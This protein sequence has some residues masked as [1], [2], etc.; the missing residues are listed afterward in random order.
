M[1]SIEGSAT[2]AMAA[3]AA[4]LRAEGHD[5]IGL[6]VGEPDFPTPPHVREAAKKA[7][8]DGHTHY[9]PGPGI[10][11]LR[12]AIAS[13]TQHRNGIACEA[14]HVLATPTKQAVMMALQALAG[15]GDEVILPD[16]GWVSY[17]PMVHWAGATPVPVAQ[18]AEDDFRMTPESVAEAITPETRVLLLN[19]P[20]N[21]TGGINTPDDV[22]G[23]VEL[24][25][26][27]NLWI[28]SDEIYQDILYE[29]TH[30]SPASLDG[31]FDRTITVDG[32]SKSFAMT[33]WRT[34]WLV[35]PE[36]AFKQINKLQSHSITHITSFAQY[37][38]VAAL[39]GPMDAVETM[40]EA[41]RARRKILLDGLAELGW[42]CASPKGAFYAFPKAPVTAEELLVKAHVATTAG[43][44]FGTAG[45]GHLRI[46]YATSED[47]LREALSRMAALA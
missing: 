7:L 19:S 4:A 9:T 32:L 23:L 34:G 30:V 8:D 18:R 44:A 37:G 47:R 13:F 40:K 1:A 41:F 31:G 20:S 14:S 2:V 21:P 27:H 3:K 22:R 42:E 28:I 36:P 5:V 12:A 16:P 33:G 24:A 11:E 15:P 45:A 46:S 38:A 6:S 25:E 35:A 29:G 26:D 10:P 39:T 17:G 43:D